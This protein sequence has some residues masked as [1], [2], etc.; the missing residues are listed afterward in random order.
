MEKLYKLMRRI[1]PTGLHSLFCWLIGVPLFFLNYL[2]CMAVLPFKRIQICLLRTDRLGHLALEPDIFLRRQ[3]IKRDAVAPD[4]LLTIFIRGNC[5]PA[6]KQLLKM[7]QRELIILQLPVIYHLMWNTKWLWL[8]S[9]FFVNTDME[10]NEFQEFNL[11]PS[12]LKFNA[13]E[14]V[15][16]KRRLAEFEIDLEHNWFV[17]IFARDDTYLKAIYPG[18]D[19]SYHD[20]RNSDIDTYN[21]AIEEIVSRGGYVFRMG[22]HVNKS[23]SIDST[24]VIDYANGCRSDFMDIYL[25]AKCRFF[26]GSSSGICDVSVIFD[27]PRLGVNCTPFG[28]GPIG[29]KSLFIP[30]LLVKTETGIKINF[31]QLLNDFADSADSKLG[32]GHT[33]TLNGYQYIDNTAYE[34]LIVTREMLDRLDSKYFHTED[35]EGLQKSYFDLMPSNHWCSMVKTPICSDFLKQ[36]I[37]LLR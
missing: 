21:L 29:K 30:K 32:N 16:G 14:E 1:V 7:W 37:S 23:I 11:A 31:S 24:R 13:D 25:S 3:W 2:V 18:V 20:Y 34:I 36:N 35:S 15:E 10:S 33:A 22:S 5:P 28:S 27:R 9:Q 26:L 12:T 6:N 4:Q 19:F 8:K 17:C